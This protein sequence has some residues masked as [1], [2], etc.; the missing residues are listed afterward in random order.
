MKY[1]EWAVLCLA[2]IGLLALCF[3]AWVGFRVL[4]G[5]FM[6]FLMAWRARKHWERFQKL[7]EG[8]RKAIDE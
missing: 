2:G 7:P 3:F 8:M 6:Q 4:F 1:I 5:D